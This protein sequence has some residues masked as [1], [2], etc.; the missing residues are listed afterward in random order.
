VKKLENQIVQLN[1]QN[2]SFTG[3]LNKSEI[4]KLKHQISEKDDEIDEHEAALEEYKDGW[5][6]LDTENMDLRGILL[7]KEKIIQTLIQKQK[8]QE[9][10][11]LLNKINEKMTTVEECRSWKE[12]LLNVIKEL[13]KKKEAL[14]AVEALEESKKDTQI[15]LTCETNERDTVFLPCGHICSCYECGLENTK[16]PL[17]KKKIKSIKKVFLCV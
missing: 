14:L 15:C 7:Q 17:C 6:D 13:G 12:D 4:L 10:L 2:E 8:E 3:N 11:Q 1:K 16:C 5:C 9:P